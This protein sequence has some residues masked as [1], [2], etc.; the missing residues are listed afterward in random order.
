MSIRTVLVGVDARAAE[1]LAR[2]AL[3]AGAL[4]VVALAVE[5]LAVWVLPAAVEA[6]VD[7]LLHV[8]TVMA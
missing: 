5:A 4:A 2:V 1:A 6:A 8:G 3:A 7:V